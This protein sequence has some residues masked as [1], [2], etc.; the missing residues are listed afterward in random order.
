MVFDDVVEHGP[1]SIGPIGDVL[2]TAGQVPD[3]PA[4]DGPKGQFAGLR[5]LPRSVDVFQDPRDFGAGEVG[6][7]QQPRFLADGFFRAVGL[8]LVASFGGSA[9]LPHNRVVDRFTRFPVPYNRRLPLIG[10]THR[11]QVTG[12]YARLTQNLDH[13]AHLRGEDVEGVMLDPTALGVD[14]LEFPL[15]VGDDVAVFAKENGTRAG[16]S[17][18]ERKNVR[19]GAPWASRPRDL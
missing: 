14:L 10:D 17:L 9:I 2:F 6:I 12:A 11:C 13:R 5:L 8:H 16:G 7:D 15:P 4:I 19:H 3:Q 1:R 18:V